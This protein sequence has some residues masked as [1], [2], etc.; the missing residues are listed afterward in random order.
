MEQ[1]NTNWMVLVTNKQNVELKGIYPTKRAAMFIS[2]RVKFN[3][4][5]KYFPKVVP[6]TADLYPEGNK[7]EEWLQH[8]DKQKQKAKY[9]T[10]VRP[11]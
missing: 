8:L 10:K 3:D 9:L 1:T 5:L 4:K 7:V 11:R 2:Q 6:T